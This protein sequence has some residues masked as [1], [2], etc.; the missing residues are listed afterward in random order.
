MTQKPA[1]K[2]ETHFLLSPPSCSS[3]L[4][5]GNQTWIRGLRGKI[6]ATATTNEQQQRNYVQMT[7]SIII[8]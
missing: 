3:L 7:Q 1:I 2:Y 6:A 4:F 5:L 8:F